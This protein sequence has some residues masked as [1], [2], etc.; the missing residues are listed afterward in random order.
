MG[1]QPSKPIHILIVGLTNAGKTHFLDMFHLGPDSTKSATF[2]Y[3]EAVYYFENY[4]FVMTE[5]GGSMDWKIM[6]KLRKDEP[7]FHCMY[8]VIGNPSVPP[9]LADCQNSLLMM[10]S[11]LPQNI[12]IAILWNCKRP[13]KFQYPRNRRIC[14]F[15][16][17]FEDSV[18]WLSKTYKLFQWTIEATHVIKSSV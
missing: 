9:D 16:L 4:E 1:Q 6:L 14:S 3:Y 11:L 12:P 10:T 5:Y 8:F 13:E 18:E 2:G 7:K 17:N 15:T